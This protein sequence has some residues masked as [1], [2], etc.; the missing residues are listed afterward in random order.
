MFLEGYKYDLPHE[1]LTPFGAAQYA[2]FVVTSSSVEN[3]IGSRSFESGQTAYH[4]YAHLVDS[5]NL[6]FVRAASE[7]RVVSSAGNWT[8]GTFAD[9]FTGPL[10]TD[11][12]FPF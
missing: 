10:A 12:P 6:P 3:L 8:V 11:G 9:K 5:E 1:L 4:R 2:S 7:S